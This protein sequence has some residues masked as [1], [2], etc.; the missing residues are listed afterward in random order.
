MD[1]ATVINSLGVGSPQVI[2]AICVVALGIVGWT[3]ARA[4]IQSYRERLGETRET[5]KQQASDSRLMAEAMREL[6]MTIDLAL[7]ALRGGNR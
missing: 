2:L 6:R 3:L 7:S 1:A 5:L 4:L